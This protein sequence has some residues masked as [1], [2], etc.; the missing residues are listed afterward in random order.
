M[1]L[2]T[3][4]L[5]E[6]IL[7]D[8]TQLCSGWIEKKTGLQGDFALVFRGKAD[9]PIENM[10]DLEDVAANAPI[11]S[12]EMLHFIVEMADPDLEKA[13]MHQRLLIAIIKESL[14]AHPQCSF[15]VRKGDDIYD[16]DAKLTV[17]IATRSTKSSLIHIGINIFS[18]NTPLLTKGLADYDIEPLWLA[19]KVCSCFTAELAGIRHACTKVRSVK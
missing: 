4:I 9:V 5:K 17:S 3:R 19:E 12:E 18:H 16:G 11:Y 14:K 8:G 10:V 7:Y 13:V 1:S 2:K 15:L 6:K